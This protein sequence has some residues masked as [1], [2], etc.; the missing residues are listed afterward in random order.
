MTTKDLRTDP[1]HSGGSSSTSAAAGKDKHARERTNSVPEV[2]FFQQLRLTEENR[3]L[4]QPYAAPVSLDL[5]PGGQGGI[6][7]KGKS[8]KDILKL[9]RKRAKMQSLKQTSERAS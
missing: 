9:K 2:V 7:R 3:Q 6:R 1:Y 5:K 4:R 8:W